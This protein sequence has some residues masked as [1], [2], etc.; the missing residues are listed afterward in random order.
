MEDATNPSMHVP[1]LDRQQAHHAESMVRQSSLNAP[2]ARTYQRQESH[3][4]IVIA[5]VEQKLDL[6]ESYKDKTWLESYKL[7]ET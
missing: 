3:S 5:H 2:T 7:L 4:Q 1:S 6:E